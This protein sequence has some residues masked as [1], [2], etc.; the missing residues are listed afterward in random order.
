M[1]Y[2]EIPQ[3]FCDTTF[4][5]F[6]VSWLVTRHFLF[7]FVIYSTYTDLPRLVTFLWSK[8][9]GRYLSRTTWIIF[10]ALLS[11][12]QVTDISCLA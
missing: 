11:A 8:E 6:L 2:I 5:W 12:L 3:I 4:A 1:R 10:C 9:L 7:L